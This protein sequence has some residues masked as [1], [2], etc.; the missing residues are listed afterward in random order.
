MSRSL[1][2]IALAL[3]AL[4]AMAVYAEEVIE[5]DATVNATLAD[6]DLQLPEGELVDEY[7]IELEAGTRIS[8]RMNSE[9]F[10]TYLIFLDADAET[11]QVDND[12]FGG[13]RNSGI[14]IE[15]TT[16][17]MCVIGATSYGANETGAYT[18]TVRAA[19]EE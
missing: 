3:L 2:L 11:P 5:L 1:I 14:D 4:S 12:D 10:D 9:D 18:L 8:I 16:T 6:G 13:A 17:G 7:T 19:E 15:V